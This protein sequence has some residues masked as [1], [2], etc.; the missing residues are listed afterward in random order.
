MIFPSAA[1]NEY[2]WRIAFLLGA[3]TLPFGFWVIRR[4]PET[5]HR[6]EF[7]SSAVT[8]AKTRMAAV[9]ENRKIIVIGLI[10]CAAGPI[11]SYVFNYT[12]VFSQNTLHMSPRASF[13]ASTIGS[14]GGVLCFLVGGWLSDRIGRRPVM[15]YSNL[16]FLILVYPMYLW[17]VQSRSETALF[18]STAVRCI[19]VMPFGIFNA[20]LAESLPK[21]IRSSSF[22]TIYATTGAIFGGTCQLFVT[23][24]IH[25]TGNPMALTWYLL[26]AVA[27]AQIAF[28]AMPE[29]APICR[30]RT[31][32]ELA[33]STLLDDNPQAV[34]PRELP[35][36][37][38]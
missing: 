29:S 9:R 33:A 26:S 36:E 13:E 16:A 37:L 15:I 28:L 25:F 5:L 35:G 19:G 3:F 30:N 32:M 14:I 17:M 22:A 12:A 23:W 11:V 20:A 10:A 38:V 4:I 24:L 2:G 27:V 21:S 7:A 18:V 8:K 34:N 1:L 31:E 6:K